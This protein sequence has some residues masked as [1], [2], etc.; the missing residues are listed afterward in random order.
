MH[1]DELIKAHRDS[2]CDASW[3]FEQAVSWGKI[4]ERAEVILRSLEDAGIRASSI[5]HSINTLDV[6][7]YSVSDIKGL[8]ES[9]INVLQMFG[10]PL[11]SWKTEDTGSYRYLKT[12]VE[13]KLSLNFCLSPDGNKC[14]FVKV[15]ET[16]EEVKRPV[17]ELQCSDEPVAEPEQIL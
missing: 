9:L 5:G 17:Y 4:E 10:Y 8:G 11:E 15:S 7:F 2:V 16:V 13:G 14:K 6:H 1:T 12:E 3:I